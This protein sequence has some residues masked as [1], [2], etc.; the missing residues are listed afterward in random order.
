[1]TSP[2]GMYVWEFDNKE[3]DLT[4]TVSY[5]LWIVSLYKNRLSVRY[6]SYPGDSR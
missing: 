4:G 3:G 2:G 5:F 1:M 6:S